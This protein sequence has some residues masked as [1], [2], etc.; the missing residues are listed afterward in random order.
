M[1]SDKNNLPDDDIFDD[2][3]FDG[4]DD[5]LDSTPDALEESWDEIAENDA[6]DEA[7]NK[8]SSS[9]KV[10]K[11]PKSPG[12]KSSKSLL[13]IIGIAAAGALGLV[14]VG[15]GALTSSPSPAPVAEGDV[16]SQTTSQETV[17]TEV[18]DASIPPMPAPMAADTA[19][20]ETSATE[21]PVEQAAPD[22]TTLDSALTPMPGAQDLAA[23]DAPQ[24]LPDLQVAEAPAAPTAALEPITMPA[25]EST[26]EPVNDAAAEPT[27]EP[28]A[29]LIAAEGTSLDSGV[30]P[31][32]PMPALQPTLTT[33]VP[34]STSQASDAS[35]ALTERLVGLESEMARL[36]KSIESSLAD[37]NAKLEVALATIQSLQDKI[38][39]LNNQPA[40]TED[41]APRAPAPETE[42]VLENITPP[43][44]QPAP[45]L[46]TE[47]PERPVQKI[48]PEETQPKTSWTLRSA[49]TGSAVV[50]VSG[51]NELRNIE[52]GDSLPGI[53]KIQSIGMENGSWVVRGTRGII[54]R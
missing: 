13:A 5:A 15:S 38:N 37:S 27:P 6:S 31:S 14:V 48:Q 17:P 43:A 42:P 46:R 29:E 34:P 16:A 18:T 36:Q 49:R 3:D 41:T 21:L 35:V 22:T 51:S 7:N 11:T 20:S 30:V 54:S 4:S 24:A 50:S 47:T 19:Q 25:I 26:A 33:D 23:S 28:A 53:G 39:T 1:V 45:V 8:S 52:V 32:E 40:Q 44:P 2:I 12:K 9:K 10:K